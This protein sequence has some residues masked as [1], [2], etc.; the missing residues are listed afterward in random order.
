RDLRERGFGDFEGHDDGPSYE[1]VWALDAL[2]SRHGEFGVEPASEV[3]AR[4]AAVVRR[5]LKEVSIRRRFYTGDGQPFPPGPSAVVLVSHGDALQL[6]QCLLAGRPLEQHRSLP[7]LENCGVRALR[8]PQEEG[9]GVGDEGE[10]GEEGR[11]G[12]GG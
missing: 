4:T 3:A 8:P 11:G 2:S 12:G 7:H 1:K 9:E 5:V 6:L 10:G